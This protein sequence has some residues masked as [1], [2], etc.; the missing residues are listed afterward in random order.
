MD[1]SSSSSSTVTA[2]MQGIYNYI[3]EANH[4]SRVYG[5]AT[6]LWLQYLVHEML[7]PMFNVLYFNIS[8]F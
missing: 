2:F 7:F 6:V 4:I 5:V 8:M 1:L 3:P